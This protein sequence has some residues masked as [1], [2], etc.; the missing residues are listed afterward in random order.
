M[1]TDYFKVAREKLMQHTAKTQENIINH[2]RIQNR[3]MDE[4]LKYHEN[5]MLESGDGFRCVVCQCVRDTYD[6]YAREHGDV[7][8]P[9]CHVIAEQNEREEKA[10]R[11]HVWDTRHN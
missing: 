4:E 9:G 3:T 8:S 6:R 2:L 11:A 1:T 7:C 5:R 10:E